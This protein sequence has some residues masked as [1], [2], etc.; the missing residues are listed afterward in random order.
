MLEKL[1]N[2]PVA[3]LNDFCFNLTITQI[4]SQVIQSHDLSPHGLQ[5]SVALLFKELD[6]EIALNHEVCIGILPFE[7]FEPSFM[8][9][10]LPP[11]SS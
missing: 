10:Y 8:L 5:D 1:R 6:V 2:K 7:F 3:S 9:K 4:L 11:G